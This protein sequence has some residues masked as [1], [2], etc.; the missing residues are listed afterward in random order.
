MPKEG[1]WARTQ[2]SI[3]LPLNTCFF[4]EKELPAK[5]VGRL[6]PLQYLSEITRIPCDEV[7]MLANSDLHFVCV[8]FG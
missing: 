7:R 3:Y 8:R 1:N 4:H 5:G 6:C 2:T